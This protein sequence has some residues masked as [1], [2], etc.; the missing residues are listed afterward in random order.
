MS[1]KRI[2]FIRDRLTATL[3]IEAVINYPGEASQVPHVAI[4]CLAG[5]TTILLTELSSN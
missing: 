5:R 3:Q 1:G 2:R 4:C